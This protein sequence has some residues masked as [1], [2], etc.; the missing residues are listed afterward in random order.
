LRLGR[1]AHK[2]FGKLGE[3]QG[4]RLILSLF[5]KAVL[6]IPRIFHFETLQDPGFAILSGGRAVLTRHALGGLIRRASL[7][8]VRRFIQRTTPSVKRAQRHTVSIDEHAVPRFTRKFNIRKGYH[9]IRNKHMKIEKLT[10]AFHTGTRQLLSILATRGHANLKEIA[11]RLLLALRRKTRGAQLRVVLD[12]GAS[13]NHAQLFELVDHPRQVTIVRVPRRPTYRTQWLQLPKHQWCEAHEP[14]PYKAA[15]DK[16]I[17]FTD[18]TMKLRDARTRAMRDVRTIVVREKAAR[19]KER[20]HALWVF[21]DDH[22][23]PWDIVC[24]FR[25]RQHHE[26]TYRVMLH[27]GYIDTAASGYNKKSAN[28]AR[29]GFKQNAITLYAW[30]VA[31]ATHAL[32]DF[33]TMLSPIFRRAH[34]R[35]LRRWFLNTPAM[36]FLGKNTL[37]VALHPRAKLTVWKHLIERI[38]RGHF[39][40]PWLDNR[41]LILS[42]VRSPIPN[43]RKI[44]MIQSSRSHNVWC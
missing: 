29:P 22:S 21:G 9:T 27:D 7:A 4:L 36:L 15:P 42:L 13:Q 43:V 34:P 6:G 23:E 25:S 8:E 16:V 5:F 14:G 20:W 1:A 40:L 31:L 37:I 44:E 12:A 38:N 11:Q 18:T 2:C 3:D 19:G 26:Q 32:A 30:S 17:H 24:E 39:R 35:T 33:S 28:P 10:F 41:R